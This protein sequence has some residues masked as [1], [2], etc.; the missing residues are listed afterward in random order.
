MSSDESSPTRFTS[1]QDLYRKA[2]QHIKQVEL[3]QA[4]L[5]FG[6]INELRYAGHHLLK[7]LVAQESGTPKKAEQEMPKTT[8]TVRCT[9]HPKL[10][11]DASA[12]YT[13]SSKKTT[14]ISR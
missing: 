13:G 12:D 4:E 3:C 14:R 8:A 1:I 6:A 7:G 2:E 11:L 10:E 5:P 9:R